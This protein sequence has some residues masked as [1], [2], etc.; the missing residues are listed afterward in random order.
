VKALLVGCAVIA[1][2]CATDVHAKKLKNMSRPATAAWFSIDREHVHV[3]RRGKKQKPFVTFISAGVYRAVAEDAQGTYFVGPLDC[4][5]FISGVD[6]EKYLREPSPQRPPKNFDHGEWSI[7]GGLWLPKQGINLPP[8]LFYDT[9]LVPKSDS[10]CR[11]TWGCSVIFGPLVTKMF[12]GTL[13]LKDYAD[14]QEFV[15][16]LHVQAGEPPAQVP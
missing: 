7:I 5:Q 1:L 15:N 13:A 12:E 8:K 2:C 11:V 10:E 6:A 9:R 4:L 16:S 3:E 14:D